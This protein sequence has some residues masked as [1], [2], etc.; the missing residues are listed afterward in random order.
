MKAILLILAAAMA[1]TPNF[2]QE[3]MQSNV[4]CVSELRIPAYPPLARSARMTGTALASGKVGN[5]GH[6]HEIEV[7]GVAKLLREVVAEKLQQSSF[8]VD[9][10]GRII[11]VLFEFRVVGRASE[12][13]ATEITFFGPNRF[14]IA[15]QPG[16]PMP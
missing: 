11:R 2:A 14:L 8:S 6:L 10:V 1:E 15:T 13:P 5:D 16:V 9:C 4:G 3:L 7:T 12:N